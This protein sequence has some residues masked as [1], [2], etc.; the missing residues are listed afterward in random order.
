MCDVMGSKPN[1]LQGV[2]F[3]VGAM[4]LFESITFV[5]NPGPMASRPLPK[6]VRR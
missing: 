3:D 1:D 4:T 6:T 2:A 5:V